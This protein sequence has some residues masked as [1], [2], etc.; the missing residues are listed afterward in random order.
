M[1]T[2][3]QGLKVDQW[4]TEDG[5]GG[6]G[7]EEGSRKGRRKVLICQTYNGLCCILCFLIQI[8]CANGNYRE[9]CYIGI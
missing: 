6:N 1:E 7:Q 4:L 9:Y 5:G 8:H 2:H 3:E